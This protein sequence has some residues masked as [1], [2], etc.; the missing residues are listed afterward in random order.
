MYPFPLIWWQSCLP[1]KCINTGIKHCFSCINIRQV[2]REVLNSE[3]TGRGFQHLPEDLANVIALKNYVRSLL[4]H[5]H[6]LYFALFLALFC[7]AFSPVSRKRN[8]HWLCSYRGL[9]VNTSWPQLIAMKV[10]LTCEK[11]RPRGRQFRKQL[12]IFEAPF[13]SWGWSFLRG[14]VI[15]ITI[16]LP[17]CKHTESCVGMH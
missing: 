8:C 10:S 17:R 13:L 1:S 12:M 15:W 14:H 11:W 16:A 3:A 9:A 2:P 7:F 5:K 6:L 4:L